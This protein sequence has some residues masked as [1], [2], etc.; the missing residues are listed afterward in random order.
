MKKLLFIIP[1]LILILGCGAN[2]MI[3]NDDLSNFKD[4]KFQNTYTSNDNNFGTFL[5][6][7]WDFAFNKP[8]DT[9]PSKEIPIV[10]LTKKDIEKMPD[11]SMVR[12]SHSTLL[13]KINNKLILTDPMFSNRASPVSFAGPKRFHPNPIEIENLPNIDLVLISHNHYDHLDEMSITKLKDK[14]TKFLVPLNVGQYLEK[15]GV[16]NNKITQLNWWEKK[17]THNLDFVATPSQH[18]SG[19]GI[20]DKD[21]TLWVSWVIK[22]KDH[23]FY[24]SGDSGY[25]KD[26]KKIGD[27]YG[28]FTMTFLEVGAYNKRW[29]KVHMFPKQAVQAN[30]DLRGAVMFPVHNGT[31]DLAFH[32]WDEPF[33][34]IV[35]AAKEQNVTIVTP[36]MG[37]I[38]SLIK[39]N[40]TSSWWK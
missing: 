4:N 40:T 29:E 25:S 35:N 12:L 6:I 14:T 22:S 26:F 15:F 16:K 39:K 28:P 19:R 24:F 36:K 5:K 18:F 32:S 23:S 13:F 17:E 3:T 2:K 11:Y 20:F 1:I 33:E 9:Q 31:F 21:T 30:I 38:I 37:E 27:K 7:A 34:R 10:Q 8:K